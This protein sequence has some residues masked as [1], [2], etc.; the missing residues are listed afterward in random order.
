MVNT[1]TDA[2]KEFNKDKST[3]SF[4]KKGTED[5]EKVKKIQMDLKS[6][7]TEQ[8]KVKRTKKIKPSNIEEP[9]DE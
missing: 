3:F 6:G 9:K 8:P 7:M 2:L 1:W 5:Y 4:V